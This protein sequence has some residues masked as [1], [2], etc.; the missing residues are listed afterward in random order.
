MPS[1]WFREFRLRIL[2][3]FGREGL[4]RDLDDELAFHL[5]QRADKNRASGMDATEARHAAHRQLGNATNVKERTREIRILTSLENAWRDVRFGTRMLLKEPGFTFIVILTLALGIGANTAIFSII[6]GFML[7]P[8]PIAD[9]H[10]VVY[11][12]FPQGPENFDHGFSY[13]E[14][15]DIQKQTS[16][17]FSSSAG[18]ILGATA[19]FENQSD[20]L[21]LDG[22]TE[23]VQAS[24][25]HSRHF[26][27]MLGVAPELGRLIL[28]GE[29][30][31]P[32]ADPVAVIS[33]RYWKT[34][35][36]ADP[37]IIGK[38]AAINGHPVTIVSR[39][40]HA[41]RKGFEGVTPLLAM[42]A[43]LPLGMATVASDGNTDFIANPKTH[44]I[45]ILARWKPGMKS[46]KTQPALDIIGQRLFQENARHEDSS[47]LRAI[48]F[49]SAHRAFR[50]RRA[51]C[52]G[53]RVCF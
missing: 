19:G 21:T 34:R 7:R 52:P 9:P 26:F 48:P 12:A 11:L 24:F 2:S 31:S 17:I 40:R 15:S 46:A 50:I 36:H 14:F 4:D 39:M 44:E 42:Q 41:A 51:C 18:V 32:G 16:D 38:Q 5:A 30:K 37:S 27:P 1:N 45:V 25:C 13:Q 29:G 47:S 49:E 20:G 10:S 6:N 22:H 3:L 8:L 33:D 28:P 53:S 43:Y 35:F 23:P